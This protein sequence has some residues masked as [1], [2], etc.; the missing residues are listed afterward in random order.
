M[1]SFSPLVFYRVR[2]AHHF[3]FRGVGGP[4]SCIRNVASVPGLSIL[5]YHFGFRFHYL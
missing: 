4:V 3:S 1:E 5:N 2:V